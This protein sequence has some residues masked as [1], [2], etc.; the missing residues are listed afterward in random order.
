MEE[1]FHL[2]PPAAGN[3]SPSPEPT[4]AVAHTPDALGA[5]ELI[6]EPLALVTKPLGTPR[7]RCCALLWNQFDE[8]TSSTCGRGLG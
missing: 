8:L 3:A 1:G 7:P 5:G 6:D 2:F 4:L